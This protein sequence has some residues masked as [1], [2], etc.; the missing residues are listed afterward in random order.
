MNVSQRPPENTDIL[1][2]GAGPA[3]LSAAAFAGGL[4]FDVTVLD[5]NARPGGQYYRQSR[6]AGSLPAAIVG[7]SQ[8]KGRR[9]LDAL[10][11]ARVRICCDATVW[12]TDGV[13]T[14]L[15]TQDGR[16]G[17][18]SAKAI[19]LA[20]GAHERVVPFPG[21]TLPGVMTAGA[22][23]TLLK[24]QAILPGRNIVIAGSGPFLY[25]VATQLAAAGGRIGAIC[26]LSR[27]RLWPL[28]VR[29][30]HRHLAIYKEAFGYLLRMRRHG[31]SVEFGSTV[32]EASGDSA[33][34]EVTI[35]LMDRDMVERPGTRR[36]VAAD[37]LLTSF[38]FVPNTQIARLLGCEL[39]WDETQQAHFVK[40]DGRLRTSHPG[41][42]VAGEIAG[43]GGHRVAQAEG[44]LA[45]ASAVEELSSPLT[46]AAAS[47]RR[48]AQRAQAACREFADHMLKTFALKPGIVDLALPDTIVCRCESVPRAEIEYH[49]ALWEGSQR[50]V[51][52]NTRCGMGRCQGRIC[53][54]AAGQFIARHAADAA[55]PPVPD[56]ARMPVKPLRLTG[57]GPGAEIPEQ[58]Q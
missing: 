28:R 32:V 11:P 30:P 3:G 8:M 36:T 41:I 14:L 33:L 57:F 54:Y 16:T 50:A 24:A 52:Q 48:Q 23:Q 53:G 9:L 51:K 27:S 13:K 44:T 26:E 35:A 29:R 43:I 15:Y 47:R 55:R 39:R 10:D 22:A 20:T 5:E 2:V 40:A 34:R 37:T 12:G 19:I 56:P 42:Y 38:G 4:G 6:L 17:R 58:N 45:A 46:G 21:W 1:V 49:G 18:I 31:L 25:P 7:P